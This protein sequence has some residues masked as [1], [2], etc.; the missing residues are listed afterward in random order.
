[1][2][3]PRSVCAPRPPKTVC[4]PAAAEAAAHAAALTGLEQ[5]HEDQEDADDD[6]EDGDEGDQRS[7][8]FTMARKSSALRLAPPTSAPST[9]GWAMSS[10]AF[11]GFT[12]PPYWIRIC[13]GDG[14]P[15][16]AEDAPD[17]GVDLLRLG[18]G[19]GL[20]GA[21]RPHR[22]V[23][24]RHLARAAS[25]S[26]PASPWRTWRSTTSSVRPASRSASVSPTQTMGRRP[27]REQRADL[28]AHGLVGLAEELA[29][30]AV[31]HD[32]VPAA[33]VGEH[34]RRRPRR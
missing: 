10:A 21:D 20:A 16:L 33:G 13:V 19:G 28:L 32:A 14:A 4:A 25:A 29:P 7:A 18:G 12:E 5:D 11:S 23:G 26:R 30:L 27:A 34:R 22:L 2:T 24:D 15:E 17:G 31:A 8:P 1:M 3:L 6:V 9:S